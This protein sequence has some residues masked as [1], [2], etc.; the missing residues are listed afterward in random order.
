MMHIY[1]ETYGCTMNRADSEIIKALLHDSLTEDFKEADCVI[2][3]SCG[4]KGPTERKIKK[5][6]AEIFAQNKALIVAGCLPKISH[7]DVNV[8]GTNVYDIVEAVEKVERGESVNLITESRRNKLCYPREG[9]GVCALIPISEGCL[10]SCTY[11]AA[12]L[13]RGHLFSYS[14]DSII[15]SARMALSKGYKELQI[16]SQD[17]GCYGMDHGTRLPSLLRALVS[18]E[19]K[20]KI[21]IGMMNPDH[22]SDILDDLIDVYHDPKIFTFLHVPVQSGNDEILKK[23]NRRYTVDDF[24]EI[25]S[26]FRRAFPHLCLWT[27]IITGFPTETEEQFQDTLT[28]VKSTAPDKINVT[29][30]SP[31]PNT[32]AALMN[33]IPGWIKKE[34]SRALHRLRMK[35]SY[36]INR[37]YVGKSYEVLIDKEGVVPSTMIGRTSNYKP[38]VCKG[39]RGEFKEVI[40]TDAHPTY[41]KAV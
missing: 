18:L 37:S 4:V 10:G 8:V 15:R 1:L 31:R 13:A 16:T 40:I 6:I 22:V 27:D 23:M 36:S 34:R 21:R 12:R 28:M 32:P 19:G 35:I 9:D 33:Q 5:R 14:V 20:F 26:A 41:L 11:C 2:I 25:C 7:L 39:E 3:N 38:V 29:R 17:T 30:Y 24:K